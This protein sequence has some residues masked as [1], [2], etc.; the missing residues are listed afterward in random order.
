MGGPKTNHEATKNTKAEKIFLSFFIEDY[1]DFAA[2]KRL[3]KTQEI[4]S[5]D[6]ADFH[7]I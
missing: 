2:A 1:E 4:L 5:A 3:T 7:G 6:Y